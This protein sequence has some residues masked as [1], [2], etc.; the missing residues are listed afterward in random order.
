V[1]L[2]AGAAAK[3]GAGGALE[4]QGVGGVPLGLSGVQGG[5]ALRGGRLRSAVPAALANRY[6]Q[7]IFKI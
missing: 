6:F 2:G 4:N 7:L 5:G 1:H 3:D